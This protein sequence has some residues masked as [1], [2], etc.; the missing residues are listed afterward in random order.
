[1]PINIKDGGIH[2]DFKYDNFMTLITILIA[3]YQPYWEK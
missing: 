2:E 3:S 1:M